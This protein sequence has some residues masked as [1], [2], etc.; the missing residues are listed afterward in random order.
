[1]KK[2]RN[3]DILTAA[4]ILLERHDSTPSMLTAADWSRLRLAVRQT[5]KRPTLATLV[6]SKLW[7]DDKV[8]HFQWKLLLFVKAARLVPGGICL[9]TLTLSSEA[10]YGT[11]N[12]AIEAA[13]A[14]ARLFGIRI[15]RKVLYK[16]MKRS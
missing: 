4:R 2:T 9:S 8:Y 13:K 6:T 10:A 14:A 15:D 1:M 11:Q 7:L 12:E 5:E 3:E 16:E